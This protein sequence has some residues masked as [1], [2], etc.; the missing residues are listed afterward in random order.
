MM[1]PTTTFMMPNAVTNKKSTKKGAMAGWRKI[2]CL[3]MSSHQPSKV[4]TWKRVNI[5]LG[6][7]PKYSP[8]GHTSPSYEGPV[9]YSSCCPTS[10]VMKM[11]H[12]YN[13]RTSTINTQPKALMDVTS[14][15]TS[16]QS[17]LNTLHERTS[18]TAGMRRSILRMVSSL[19]LPPLP[20]MARANV[21]ITART[22]TVKSNTCQAS[23][24]NF[25]P[26]HSMR[27]NISPRKDK[28]KKT[29]MKYHTGRSEKPASPLPKSC[30]NPMRKAFARTV[31]QT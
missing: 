21:S 4:I 8:C 31:T 26:R 16:S 5:D 27:I 1:T 18:R 22:T 11:A 13:I 7:V 15:P 10:V 9:E 6:T 14:P 25:L 23:L 28:L 12:T 3:T 29:S 30:S 17:S 20:S 2:T 24:K 19:S